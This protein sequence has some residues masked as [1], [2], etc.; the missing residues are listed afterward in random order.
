MVESSH[1]WDRLLPE[2]PE[3]SVYERAQCVIDST[4]RF[5][6]SQ[7]RAIEVTVC[8]RNVCRRCSHRTALPRSFI[9]SYIHTSYE[10]AESEIC[11]QFRK[12]P[13]VRGQIPERVFC[14]S[15]TT[16]TDFV[17]SGSCCLVKAEKNPR[18]LSSRT[19]RERDAKRKAFT[20]L[21]DVERTQ[22]KT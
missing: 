18:V 19:P 7:R 22:K 15:A 13:V 10:R 3:C 5:N 14:I 8:G 2:C 20:G 1:T 11:G 4:C 6:N 21:I 16:V 12:T 17:S 9:S